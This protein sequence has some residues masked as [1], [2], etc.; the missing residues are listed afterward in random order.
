ME[1]RKPREE[2]E[3]RYIAEY[4][5]LSFPDAIKVWFQLPVGDTAHDLAHRLGAPHPRWFWR[6]GRRA[7][8]VV[9]TKSDVW[10]IESETRRPIQG[11]AELMVYKERL[12]DTV[13]LKPWLSGRKV[14]MLLV[15]PFLEADT[16][17]AAKAAG[18]E[19]AV[20]RPKWIEEALIRWG[21]LPKGG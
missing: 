1:A 19:V 16:Y 20:Y 2:V 11:L 12:H 14:H 9:V 15:S 5:A 21:V 3:M 8:A 18:I 17:M 7:D 10:V 4:V 6:Y 13:H